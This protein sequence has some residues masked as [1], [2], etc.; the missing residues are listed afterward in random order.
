MSTPLKVTQAELVDRAPTAKETRAAVPQAVDRNEFVQ[1]YKSSM[2]ALATLALEEPAAHAVMY[3]L[4]ERIN[5]R[6]ALIASH[7]TLARITGKSRSTITRA[8]AVLRKRNYIQIVKA[9][10]VSIIVVNKRIVWTTDTDLRERFSIFDAQ[11]IVSEKEQDFVVEEEEAKGELLQVPPI[12]I[13]PEH[14][15]LLEDEK[16]AEIQGELDV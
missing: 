7:S 16:G 2:R 13:P 3:V 8:L 9:G 5:K 12:L 4:M 15:S 10:N 6:N 14:A 11:V 1:L